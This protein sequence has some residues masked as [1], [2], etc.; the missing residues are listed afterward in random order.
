[1]IGAIQ[2]PHHPIKYIGEN[3]DV[4]GIIV[5]MLTYVYANFRHW[6]KKC[7]QE[8]NGILGL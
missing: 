4:M 6:T 8:G 7:L 1:L 3:F 2:N 5:S